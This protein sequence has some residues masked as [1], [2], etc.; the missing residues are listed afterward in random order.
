[1]EL[2]PIMNVFFAAVTH[3]TAYDTGAPV[4]PR[5]LPVAFAQAVTQPGGSIAQATPHT[6]GEHHVVGPSHLECAGISCHLKKP[7]EPRVH[8]S[9]CFFLNGG[10]YIFKKKKFR[11]TD[12]DV[13]VDLFFS[14]AATVDPVSH[15]SQCIISGLFRFLLLFRFRRFLFLFQFRRFLFL[16]R[17]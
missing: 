4:S 14:S 8:V 2:T 13:F 7:D 12:L 16:F 15:V 3:I 5:F 17:R 6:P 10:V 1:M 9:T 11:E